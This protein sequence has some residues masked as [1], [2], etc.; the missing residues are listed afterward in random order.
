MYQSEWTDKPVL[1][2][3]PHWNWTPGQLIDVWAYT[4][5]D[6]VELLLNGNS[7]GRQKRTDE[8][9]HLV[10]RIT[11]EP[12]T[13]TGVGYKD[14]VE[15]MRQEIKTAGDPAAIILTPDRSEI[16]ADGSDLSFL[17]V[18]VVDKDGVPVPKADNLINFSVEGEGAIAGVDN[19]CQTSMEPFKADYRK[20]FNGKCLLVVRAGTEAGNISVT[21]TSDG[22]TAATTDI[23]VR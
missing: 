11:Y 12:G 9:L 23:G 10:W 1:H 2:I 15:T 20:A 8:K 4:N 22:L 17:T 7:L 16:N 6:E 13:I 18:A 19:G 5:C 14:G 3:F 21:A